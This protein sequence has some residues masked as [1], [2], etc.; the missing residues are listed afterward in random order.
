MLP[1]VATEQ[2]RFTG[3]PLNRPV[4]SDFQRDFAYYDLEARKNFLCPRGLRNGLTSGRH[5]FLAVFEEF[6]RTVS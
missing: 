6:P 2:I 4:G 1:L 3:W 5:R